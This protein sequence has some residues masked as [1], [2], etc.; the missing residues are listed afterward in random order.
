MPE[1]TEEGSLQIL[2]TGGRKPRVFEGSPEHNL[3]K[4]AG[5]VGGEGSRR[6]GVK[7]AGNEESGST[8]GKIQGR[9][10]D[11]REGK[12]TKEGNGTRGGGLSRQDKNPT[13]RPKEN[14]GKE[15]KVRLFP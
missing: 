8:G 3:M 12:R 15:P 6:S 10:P 1:G 11:S 4:E 7:E 2:G 14:S 9:P 5:V 13:S